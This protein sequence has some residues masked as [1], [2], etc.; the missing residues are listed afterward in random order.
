MAAL[1]FDLAVQVFDEPELAHERVRDRPTQMPMDA[2]GVLIEAM[3]A[4]QQADLFREIPE[5][6]RSES[7]SCSTSPRAAR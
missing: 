5:P 7:S 3:S 4:D 2:A 6:E 1:P